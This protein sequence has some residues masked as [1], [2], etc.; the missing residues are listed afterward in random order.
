[1]FPLGYLARNLW[2]FASIFVALPNFAFGGAWGIGEKKGIII[3]ASHIPQSDTILKTETDL[4]GEYGFDAKDSIV[5]SISH[6]NYGE[7]NYGAFGTIGFKRVL[8][9]HDIVLSG[10]LS[11]IANKIDRYHESENL[12]EM[13]FM[14]GRN[15]GNDWWANAEIGFRAPNDDQ[16]MSYE[17]AMGK[18]FE[19]GDSVIAKFLHDDF[20][21][22]ESIDKIQVSLIRPLSKNWSYET[23]I[24]HD[25]GGYDGKENTGVLL[26]LWYRF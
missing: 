8:F 11:A 15:F 22:F 19:N 3:A 4:Y 9:E 16:K 17:L 10:Q 14:V 26:G 2:I 1:M 5:L 7:G 24:R 23:G 12:Y 13:R 18:N 20:T 25:F 21:Y 6:S